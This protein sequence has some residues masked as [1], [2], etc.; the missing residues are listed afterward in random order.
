MQ[1]LGNLFA[2]GEARLALF[3]VFCLPT[4]QQPAVDAAVPVDHQD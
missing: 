4:I 3:K 1:E 2:L